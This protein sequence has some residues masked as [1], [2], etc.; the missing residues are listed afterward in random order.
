M[1]VRL[2]WLCG[3]ATCLAAQEDPSAVLQR[4]REKVLQTLDRLPRYM[5]TQV[6]ERTNY[7]ANKLSPTHT[8]EA[9]GKLRRTLPWALATESVD[10][11]R[12]DVALGGGNAEMYSWAGDSQFSQRPL[13]DLVA[14]GTVESGMYY[15]F[16]QMI[17]QRDAA[18]I[19]Y[20]GKVQEK[21]RSLL[22]FAFQVPRETSHW[23]Y[24][25]RAA[26]K[27]IWVVPYGG[28]FL[29]DPGTGDLVRLE[30]RATELPKTIYDCEI[31]NTFEYQLTRLN[32]ADFLLPSESRLR[33][34]DV[35]GREVVN[36]TVYSACH[37]F[38]GQST[39]QFDA[40]PDAS[41]APSPS[42]PVTTARVVPAGLPFAV[43]FT[44]DLDLDTA[45][46]GDRISARLDGDLKDL[47]SQILAPRGAAIPLW[48]FP[49]CDFPWAGAG[50][51]PTRECSP[52]EDDPY[53]VQLVFPN[54]LGRKLPASALEL[55]WITALKR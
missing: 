5:W 32:G 52:V 12:L 39:I 28:T 21:R 46:G 37:E 29:A 40:A 47:S 11:I 4:V 30:M 42:P 48:A 24:T 3:L 31:S 23:L 15:S 53:V 14:S 6:T 17:F 36:R 45:A 25:Y 7:V 50:H 27:D 19:S 33:I 44:Q 13:A 38:L 9:L 2:L 34:V 1:R 22:E 10:R 35:S 8:C 49:R 18:A 54:N 41:Q 20:R 55:S 26:P 16:L 43:A 51:A